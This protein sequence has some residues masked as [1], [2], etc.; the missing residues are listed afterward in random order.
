MNN[1]VKKYLADIGRK[2][3]ESGKGEKKKRGDSE[4]YKKLAAKRKKSK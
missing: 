2:G 3:G 1:D 4:Y